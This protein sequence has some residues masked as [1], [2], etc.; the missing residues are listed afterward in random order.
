MFIF[1]KTVHVLSFTLHVAFS[2]RK[3]NTNRG[4]TEDTCDKYVDLVYTVW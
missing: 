1:L 3:E 4:K 2:F